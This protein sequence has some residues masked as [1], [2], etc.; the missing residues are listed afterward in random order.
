MM[1][2]LEVP[3]RNLSGGMK[4][5]LCVA[6]SLIGDPKTVILD[7][8]TSGVDPHARRAV[9]DLIIRSK[10]GNCHRVCKD[11]EYL[12]TRLGSVEGLNMAE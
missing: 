6:I 3:V 12:T 2:M 4:R 7:E 5:K 11:H 8:P 9:W 10:R 1:D